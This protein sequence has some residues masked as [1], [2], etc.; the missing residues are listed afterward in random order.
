MFRR[1]LLKAG[2]AGIGTLAFS[3]TAG[4]MQS[5][6]K[7]SEKKEWAVIFGSMCGSTR[8]IVRVIPL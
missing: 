1:D 4:A 8:P 7:A 2:A 6:F 3:R 5:I